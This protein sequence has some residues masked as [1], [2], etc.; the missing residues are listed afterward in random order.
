MLMPTS[1]HR[2]LPLACLAAAVALL[3]GKGLLPLRPAARNPAIAP[4]PPETTLIIY[5]HE[6]PPYYVT[7][8]LGVYGLCADPVK[9]A[10]RRAAIPFHW[11]KLPAKRQL[12]VIRDNRLRA[13]AIGWFKTP[14]RLQFARFSRPIYRDRPLVALARADNPLIPTETTLKELLTNRK[15]TLLYKNGYS[16][17]SRVD[18]AITLCSPPRTATDSDN[19]GM[20]EMIYAGRAD[21]FFISLEEAENLTTTSGLLKSD[22]KLIHFRD[23]GAGNR[24]YLIFSRKVSEQLIQRL[25][26]ALTAVSDT[27]PTIGEE[28]Q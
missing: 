16:Y 3:F 17:G 13:A 26:T 6:R 5:Y 4:R 1:F 22:F 8:P 10:L 14:Q 28:S 7:G 2:L 9:R 21:Y 12:A 19:L 27:D 25:N 20:L 18:A 11:E 24:R 23:L 15:L